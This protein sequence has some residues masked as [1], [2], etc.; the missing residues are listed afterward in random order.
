MQIPI[1]FTKRFCLQT[2]QPEDRQVSRVVNDPKFQSDKIILFQPKKVNMKT[3]KIERG[4][5]LFSIG[6]WF[7]SMVPTSPVYNFLQLVNNWNPRKSEVVTSSTGVAL[8]ISQ[9]IYSPC[10]DVG[11]PRDLS[12]YTKSR[13]RT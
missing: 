5:T 13:H 4:K 11:H 8:K 2:H 3:L 12:M 9:V 10:C 7:L 6:S 1:Y